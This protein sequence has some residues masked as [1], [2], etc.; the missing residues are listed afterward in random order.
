MILKEGFAEPLGF[1]KQGQGFHK[2]TFNAFA[3]SALLAALTL[4]DINLT[5]KTFLIININLRV[6]LQTFRELPV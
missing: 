3:A 2:A 4:Y 5:N 1:T 6:S